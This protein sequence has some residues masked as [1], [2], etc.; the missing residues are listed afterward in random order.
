MNYK[1]LSFFFLTFIISSVVDDVYGQEPVVVDRV[2]AVVANSPILK[3]D[4][5]NQERQLESQGVDFQEN[6]QCKILDDMLY[7][8]LLYNQAI[9]DSVEV[10][11]NQVEQVLDRRLRFFIQQIGSREQLEAYYGKSIDELKDEFRPMVREQ[12]LSQMMESQIT[13]DIRVTPSEV[14]DFLRN[15]PEDSIPTVESETK[16]AHITIMPEFDPEEV[17]RTIDRLNE[18]RTR[19]LQG[20]SF[21][22]MAILYSEDPGSARKGGELGFYGRGELYPEFE[23]TAYGLAPGEISEI[24]ETQAGYHIIQM[25]ERRGD[26]INVRHILMQ[27]QISP[28][29]LN[30]ARN[31]LDSIR[32]LILKDS[33][34]FERA[35]R[36]FSDDPNKVNGGV[37]M[38]PYTNTTRFK[39][40]EID[41][42]LFFAIEKLEANDITKPVPFSNEEGKQ[43]FRIVKI[44]DRIEAHTASLETDYDFI[45]QLALEE[46]KMKEVQNWINKKINTTFIHIG[47]D[48]DHC[49]FSADW[50]KSKDLTGNRK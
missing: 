20:E 31:K 15:L 40:E 11:D 48:F 46:K 43:G 26:L 16:L 41:Q 28:L 38:N 45:Q 42:N 21:K 1:L 44:L 29:Q 14:R 37:V 17:E 4:L 19:V 32:D 30:Q 6:S 22:T 13:G 2:V 33:L 34:S 35:A 18:I 23:A 7:Q 36:K 47:N 25:I 12:E 24:I 3:S 5:Y 9:L 27:P 8:K 39:N 10:S 49:E 50:K